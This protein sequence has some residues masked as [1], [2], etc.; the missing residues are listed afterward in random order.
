MRQRLHRSP[1]C[2]IVPP[3]LL[4][5]I[6]EAASGRPA[7]VARATLDIDSEQRARRAHDPGIPDRTDAR[8]TVYDAGHGS[9]LPGRVVRR[10]D[11]PATDDETVNEA[12]A[13]LGATWRLYHEVFQRDSV[14]AAGLPLQASVHFQRDYDCEHPGIAAA[15]A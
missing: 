14:D 15:A 13:G 10:E 8:R 2:G 11:E 1:A 7:E 4:E 9:D 6:A 3:H 12:Y 5:R